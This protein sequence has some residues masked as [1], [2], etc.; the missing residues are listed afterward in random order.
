M[1]RSFAPLT[2]SARTAIER[3][4]LPFQHDDATP[5]RVKMLGQSA[6]DS[7][8]TLP[9]IAGEVQPGFSIH[10]DAA[11]DHVW[12]PTEHLIPHPSASDF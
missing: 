4:T 3:E 8:Y 6:S 7:R 9:L 10:A 12:G 5:C 1:P 2:L 11:L